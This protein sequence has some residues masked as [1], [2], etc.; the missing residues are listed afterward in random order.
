M[1]FADKLGDKLRKLKGT[2]DSIQTTTQWVLL[3]SKNFQQTVTIWENEF[4]L[5]ARPASGCGPGCPPP[6]R[7]HRPTRA[8]SHPR[9]P[10]PHLMRMYP[11]ARLPGSE[12]AALLCERCHAEQPQ[13]RSATIHPR[14][15][16]A[17]ARQSAAFFSHN[18]PPAKVGW[19]CSRRQRRQSLHPR[20]TLSARAHSTPTAQLAADE[21]GRR[22]G[23]EPG[24]FVK[25]FAKVMPG[26]M[27][28]AARCV[29]HQSGAAACRVRAPP[30][31]VSLPG[32][33]RTTRT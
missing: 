9:P 6:A 17:R 33:G 2:E 27:S 8:R 11:H 10:V 25:A 18:A 20:P 1:A 12:G 7:R 13:Q 26:C 4:N 22:A 5:G 19:C 3:Y 14:L 24:P 21:L 32:T 15:A 28:T 30:A 31:D 23:G 29:A 16:I